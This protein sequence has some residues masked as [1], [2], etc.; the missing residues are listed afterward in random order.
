MISLVK[1]TKMYTQEST[2]IKNN[3]KQHKYPIIRV[4]LIRYFYT[5]ECYVADRNDYVDVHLQIW[6]DMFK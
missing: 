1:G 5:M 4:I 2:F 6:K 3:H